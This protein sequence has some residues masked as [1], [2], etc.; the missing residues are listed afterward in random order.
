MPYTVLLKTAV[1]LGLLALP[2]TSTSSAGDQSS[3]EV[4]VGHQV[5]KGKREIIMLGKVPTR[6]E[7]F[8]LAKVKR[9]ADRIELEQRPCRVEIQETMGIEVKIP[10][11][12]LAGLPTARI[13]FEHVGS[14]RYQSKPWTVAWGKRDLDGDGHPGA[15]IAVEASLCGGELYVANR[16][17]ASARGVIAADG[18]SGT[19][20]VRVEQSI[21]GGSGMCVKLASDDSDEQQ[22]GVFTYTRVPQ[23]STCESLFRAS[24]TE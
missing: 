12:M 3:S 15:T 18:M 20:D 13:V 6:T 8:V 17:T 16:T 2:Q 1:T 21:L 24:P 14:G 9:V 19:L 5:V 11:P 22:D 23:G 7:T 4:W 10:P